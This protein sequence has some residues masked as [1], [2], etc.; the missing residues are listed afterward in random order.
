MSAIKMKKML[1][2][3]MSTLSKKE[4]ER[5]WHMQ[6]ISSNFENWRWL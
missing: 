1:L 2:T 3:G 4:S 6:N 5:T